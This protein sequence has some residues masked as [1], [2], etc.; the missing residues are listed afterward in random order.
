MN[1]GDE[2]KVVETL[3]VV[4]LYFV[5]SPLGLRL[6]GRLATTQ[7][8]KAVLRV[9]LDFVLVSAS[10]IYILGFSLGLGLLLCGTYAWKAR[11]AYSK[12]M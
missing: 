11:D 1:R 3:V 7:R 5:L 12:S 2:V 4:A 6:I 9:V 10:L 8:T